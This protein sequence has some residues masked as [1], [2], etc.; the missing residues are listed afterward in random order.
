MSHKP[1]KI[2]IITAT[3][4]AAEYLPRLIESIAAQKREDVE[5][6]VV[7]GGSKDA[8]LSILADRSD[9]VNQWISERDEGIYDAWNKGVKMA[10]GEWVMFLGADDRL[11]PRALDVFTK[12][13]DTVEDNTMI[14][15]SLLESVDRKGRTLKTVGEPWNWDKFRWS[16]LS[17]AHPGM[18]HRRQLFEK[19]GGFD[20]QFKI[21]G[22]SEFLLR[23]QLK[24]DCAFIDQVTVYMQTGGA[25]DSVRAI[26]ETFKI[27]SKNGTMGPVANTL[28]FCRLL[29]LYRA[30]KT[31]R[32]LGAKIWRAA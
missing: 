21:C 22:D 17:F 18:L 13:L 10:R 7:D 25:S 29:L 9:V 20:T 30:S 31:K 26:V 16:R 24:K 23:A 1:V 15:S 28:R 3:F 4:N 12:F 11:H 32:W 8:T 14:V 5:F 27:R 6:L 19:L 2:S